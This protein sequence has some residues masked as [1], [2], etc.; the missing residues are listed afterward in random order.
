MPTPPPLID[1]LISSFIRN[2]VFLWFFPSLFATCIFK[3]CLQFTPHWP[4][5]TYLMTYLLISLWTIIPLALLQRCIMIITHSVTVLPLWLSFF[6]QIRFLLQWILT[7]SIPACHLQLAI[8]YTWFWVIPSVALANSS[9]QFFCNILLL[10]SFSPQHHW[11]SESYIISA[12][13]CFY[14]NGS[15]VAHPSTTHYFGSTISFE[16]CLFATSESVGSRSTT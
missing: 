12:L 6:P 9:F 8:H 10:S 1:C 4:F 13:L 5:I 11:H 16:P 14:C 2:S 3:T 7:Y 15:S